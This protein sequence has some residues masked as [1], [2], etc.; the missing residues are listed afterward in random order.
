MTQHIFSLIDPLI[1]QYNE[2]QDIVL[3]LSTYSSFHLTTAVINKNLPHI[4][5][6]VCVQLRDP[7]FMAAWMHHM[8]KAYYVALSFVTAALTVQ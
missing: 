8:Q 3:C 1:H 4:S 6:S 7:A 5:T 2:P